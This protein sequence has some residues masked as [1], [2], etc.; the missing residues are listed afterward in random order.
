MYSGI[1]DARMLP[2]TSLE[3]IKYDATTTIIMI[4]GYNGKFNFNKD[5]NSSF[6]KIFAFYFSPSKIVE[7]VLFLC[8]VVVVVAVIFFSYFNNSPTVYYQYN[9]FY[10]YRVEK[11]L[12]MIPIDFFDGYYSAFFRIFFSW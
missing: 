8:V 7:Q 12:R 9:F 6:K 4:T 11:V 5:S 2:P 1:P 3:H 10:F